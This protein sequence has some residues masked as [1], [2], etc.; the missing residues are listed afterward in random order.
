MYVLEIRSPKLSAVRGNGARRGYRLP[1]Q[2]YFFVFLF[3][4]WLK[5]LCTRNRS[6]R[7]RQ[8]SSA[9]LHPVLH[10]IA[11]LVLKY[12]MASKTDPT[13]SGFPS[14]HQSGNPWQHW[15]ASA[16]SAMPTTASHARVTQPRESFCLPPVMHAAQAAKK[17][18]VMVWRTPFPNSFANTF[19][20][21]M[22]RRQMHC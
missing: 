16:S 11:K 4:F 9:T 18:K 6:P 17:S 12:N 2:E 13:S 5:L 22:L 10:F 1:M 14:I 21:Q 7:G 3:F 15:R 8:G 20:C 19:P